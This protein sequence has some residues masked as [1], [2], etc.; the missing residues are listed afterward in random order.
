MEKEIKSKK[1]RMSKLDKFLID[2]L[3]ILKD[4]HIMSDTITQFCNLMCGAI[5]FAEYIK[6]ADIVYCNEL[7][8]QI[9]KIEDWKV[10]R[11]ER[12]KLIVSLIDYIE[13]RNI[14]NDK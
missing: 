7:I 9:A 6:Q 5:T 14:D 11:L 12:K 2:K 3:N 10:N 4:I 8:T 1:K 13:N